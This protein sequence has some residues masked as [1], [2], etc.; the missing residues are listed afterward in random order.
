MTVDR[1]TFERD[2]QDALDHLY[3]PA[4]LLVHPL[5]TVLV[6]PGSAEPPQRALHRILREAIDALKPPPGAPPHSPSWRI[7][8]YLSL[9][10]AEMLTIAQ[11]A[12][13]LGISPRQCRRDHH[14]AIAA[15]C[16][17]LWEQRVHG[18]PGP[19]PPDA[20]GQSTEPNG[21]LLEAELGKLGSS[22]PT[23][24]TLLSQVVDS[25]AATLSALAA[26]KHVK[27]VVAV[28]SEL[29]PVAVERAALRQILL[30]TLL[31]A[32]DHGCGGE[33]SLHAVAD[34]RRVR[35]D[36]IAR[37]RPSAEGAQ[38]ID[39]AQEDAR[40]AVSRRLADLQG[41]ALSVSQQKGSFVVQLTLATA[42]TPVIL[43]VDDNADVLS[44][45][46]RYLDSLYDVY[47]A[48]TGEQALRLASQIRPDIITLDVMMPSQDGWE[49]LQMLKHDPSTAHIPV[50]VCSVLRERELALS[51]GAAEFLAKPVTA[52]HLRAALQRC[53]TTA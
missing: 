46:R 41:V 23:V 34:S 53:S 11:V 24:G 15:I 50:V 27:L 30:E 19:S 32:I 8:R 7:Y 44:L 6:P 39:G 47:P 49:V 16:S 42:E 3:D 31:D 13:E 38:A 35:L 17:I 52:E 25:V 36:V 45:F 48:T 33:V 51:L 10:Y 29:P 21:E 14:E 18:Q 12:S 1:D 22:P 5:A 20:P 37:S 28:S 43:V 40:L 26:R 4:Y 9:R 2:V